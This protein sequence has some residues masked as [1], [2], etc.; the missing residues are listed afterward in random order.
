MR[1]RHTSVGK[2]EIVVNTLDCIAICTMAVA[3]VVSFVCADR[4]MSKAVE[5]MRSVREI[6][7]EAIDGYRDMS[8]K[9]INSYRDMYRDMLAFYGSNKTLVAYLDEDGTLHMTTIDLTD[10]ETAEKFL[11]KIGNP[12][13][14]KEDQK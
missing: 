12:V 6:M 14:E 9:A 4:I 10:K 11:E 13:Q 2:G 8:A 7:H 3:V 5:D 1:D